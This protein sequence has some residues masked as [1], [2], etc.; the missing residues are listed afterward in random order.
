ML[1]DL[2]LSQEN[3]VEVVSAGIRDEVFFNDDYDS[4]SEDELK[5]PLPLRTVDKQ[6]L[7]VKLECI[8]VEV[9]RRIA[10]RLMLDR[11]QLLP[12]LLDVMKFIC[13]EFWLF[14][15]KK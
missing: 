8:G 11:S 9:G 6:S 7:N 4:D 10:E 5:T 3:D 2:N 13:K 12:E 14:V 15:Y 1:K